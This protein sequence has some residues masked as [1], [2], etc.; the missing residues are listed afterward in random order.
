MQRG[1]R[2]GARTAVRARR[3]ARPPPLSRTPARGQPSRLPRVCR[4]APGA[5]PPLKSHAPFRCVSVWREEESAAGTAPDGRAAP[6]GRPPCPAA[7]LGGISPVRVCRHGLRWSHPHIT[8]TPASGWWPPQCLPTRPVPVP[9]SA[10]C[11]PAPASAS[12][13]RVAPLVRPA[14]GGP[15]RPPRRRLAAHTGRPRAGRALPLMPPLPNAGTR[16]AWQSGAGGPT[17]GRGDRPRHAVGAAP[18][19]GH[20]PH[21]R[22][23]WTDF[24]L[25]VPSLHHLTA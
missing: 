16:G 2:P 7:P 10:S 23:V 14:C 13:S 15:R 12:L 19:R 22:P 1:T 4:H 8:A 17:L 24:L 5:S 3:G 21:K 20:G 9:T 25:F 18:W 11:V 6:R